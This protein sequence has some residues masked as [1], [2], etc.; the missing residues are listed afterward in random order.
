MHFSTYKDKFMIRNLIAISIFGI[1]L[2]ASLIFGVSVLAADNSVDNEAMGVANQLFNTGNYAQAAQIYEQLLSQGIVASS[3]YYNL[4]NAYYVQGDLGR[5]IL[6]YQ[7][8]ARLDPRDPDIRANLALARDQSANETIDEPSSPFQSLANFTSS[9]LT[10]D[11][12]AL[13]SLA[14]WFLLGFLILTY[15]QFQKRNF[16]TLAQ[17]GMII[18]LLIFMVSGISFGSRLYAEQ[19]RPEAVIIADQV[20]INTSPG[21]E[22]ATDFSLTSGAEVELLDIQGSWAHLALQN[23]IIDGWIPLSTIET[24]SLNE[25]E[26]TPSF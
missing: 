1:I 10:L 8:A 14:L 11:E 16:R 2:F 6:N 15:R 12:T 24:I 13:L 26:G 23:N 22:F 4:G 20:T 17:Y 9:W 18:T 25:T 3:L 7:R 5:A 19:T 21:E